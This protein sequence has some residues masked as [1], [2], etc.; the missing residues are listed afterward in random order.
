MSSCTVVLKV[1][2]FQRAMVSPTKVVGAVLFT[3]SSALR[4]RLH[5]TAF[6]A[7]NHRARGPWSLSAS[8]RCSRS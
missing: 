6:R 3:V 2:R 1:C 4:F 7:L 8:R 5:S